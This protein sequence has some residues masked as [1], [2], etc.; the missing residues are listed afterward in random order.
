MEQITLFFAAVA[1]IWLS[2]IVGVSRGL[3]SLAVDT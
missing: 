3:W 2:N 1:V